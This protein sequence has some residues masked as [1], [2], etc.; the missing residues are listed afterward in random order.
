MALIGTVREVSRLVCCVGASFVLSMSASTV[1]AEEQEHRLANDV[2]IA[3]GI[4]AEFSRGDY[5]VDA[6]ATVVTLP[7]LI[8][9]NPLETVDISLEVPL[10]FLSSRSGSGVVVTQ[11]GTAGRR[12][13]STSTT[14]TTTTTTT[15]TT[16]E[17]G[18]G[19]ISLT[20]GWTI[21]QDD[22]VLPK[23]RPTIYLKAPTGDDK[24]GLGTGT[25]EIGPGLSLSKWFG[26]VQLFTEAAYIFQDS[27][28]TYL[29]KNY[30]SYSAGGGIQT[31]DRL[32][33]SLFA[34]GSSAKVDGGAAP[35]EGHLKVNYL[36]S[37]RISWEAYAMTG[38]SDASPDI[39]AGMMLLYQF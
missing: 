33:F 34:K 39:G 26:D 9:V 6:D 27:S 32:F 30:F 3:V 25:Y 19:D 22:A 12:H 36:Q 2:G 1:G 4:G 14:T 35:I 37:R 18:V 21:V 5:G 8:V 24:L 38:F 20:A 16:K 7:V 23:V 13:G 11:S 15:S 17:S 31:T 29:G 28:N 10:V